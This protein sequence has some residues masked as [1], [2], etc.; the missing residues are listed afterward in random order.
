[1]SEGEDVFKSYQTKKPVCD[2][3]R[4]LLMDCLLNVSASTN[5]NP[6]V[7][8]LEVNSHTYITHNI[9]IIISSVSPMKRLLSILQRCK[10]LM[11]PEGATLCSVTE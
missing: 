7:V 1:M 5:T 8:L 3:I 11:C 6:L 2:F 4:I 9:L 10:T